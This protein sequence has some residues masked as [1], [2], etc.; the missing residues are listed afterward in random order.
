MVTTTTRLSKRKKLV[1]DLLKKETLHGVAPLNELRVKSI[2]HSNRTVCSPRAA[3]Y[4]KSFNR[5]LLEH[6]DPIEIQLLAT[7]YEHTNPAFKTGIFAQWAVWDLI[8]RGYLTE[9]PSTTSFRFVMGRNSCSALVSFGSDEL[10]VVGTACFFDQL[11]LVSDKF[12][13]E[14]IS[15]LTKVKWPLYTINKHGKLEAVSNS[16][17]VSK[18]D[19]LPPILTNTKGRTITFEKKNRYFY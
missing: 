19:Y 4:K 2:W 1:L 9:E 11:W 18:L 7:E 10:A 15:R 17:E 8:E 5:T 3:D 12:S 6:S 16:I 13:D 14:K